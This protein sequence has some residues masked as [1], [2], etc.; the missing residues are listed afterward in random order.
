MHDC[1]AMR[2]R[3]EPLSRWLYA[4]APS[5]DYIG[6]A[7]EIFAEALDCQALAAVFGG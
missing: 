7:D 4:A 1:S 6:A 2:A 3:F 5:S